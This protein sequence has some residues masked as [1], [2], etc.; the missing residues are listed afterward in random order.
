ML[1]SRGVAPTPLRKA[2]FR[3][4]GE[5]PRPVPAAEIMRTVRKR[6]SMNK[7]TLYRILDLLVEKGLVQRMQA[8]DRAFRY[9]MG[10]TREHPEH[11]H[12]ICT[13]C[14]DMSCLEPDLLP[15]VHDKASVRDTG[16]IKQMEVRFRG[17]CTSCLATGNGMRK[18]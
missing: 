6:L 8:G 9:G 10:L 4:I 12:F 2:V 3:A 17:I 15:E 18:E 1:K 11:P 5:Y 14:G 13:E 7:V 16:M